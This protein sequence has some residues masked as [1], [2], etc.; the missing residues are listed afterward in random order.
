MSN[1]QAEPKKFYRRLRSGERKIILLTGDFL[2]TLLA[3][4]AAL[5]AW[6]VEDWLTLSLE[7]VQV[8]IPF[9]FYLLP[10]VWLLLLTE[11]YD[12]RRASR[13]SEVVRGIGVAAAIALVLYLLVYFT[14]EPSALPR[15]GVAVFI[16]SAAVFTLLWRFLYI[17]IFTAPEFMRRV[18]IVGAGRAGS[19]LS[20]IIQGIYPPPFYLVGLIDDDPGKENETVEGYPI[21]GTGA[22]L[23][24]I[25][26]KEGVTDIIFAISVEMNPV[27]FRSLIKAEELGIEVTTMPVVYEE[28]LKRVPITLLQSD[29]IIRQFFDV[30]PTGG[31]YELVKRL[32]DIL[33]AL[34]GLLGLVFIFPPVALAIL[35]DSG[36][37]IFYSQDR[38]GKNGQVYKIFKFRTMSQDAEEDGEAKLASENDTRITRVGRFLRK[39]HLDEFPQFFNVLRGDMSLTGPRAEQVELVNILQ[40]D[41]PFYRARLLVK[42]GLTGWAQVN[43]GYAATVAQTIIKLEYDLHYIKHRNLWLDL[44]ILFRTIG[45]VVGF[46]GQ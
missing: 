9:W 31:L 11:L 10:F 8:R 46:R 15:R 6:A 25:I 45:T 27:L 41:V 33:G 21:L 38:L 3:M 14:S 26:E 35:L 13:R 17:R 44:T 36:R 16:I 1:T 20:G 28:L 34:I 43:Y 18:L 4:L 5:Y 22:Q 40:E 32:M 19:R 12:E 37:P 42:P 29:W 24:E 2:V 7:F 39:S 23:L 30:V